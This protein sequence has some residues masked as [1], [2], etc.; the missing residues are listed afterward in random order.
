MEEASGVPKK[1]GRATMS[2]FLYKSIQEFEL[3]VGYK[4]NDTF[5]D[6]W[7]MGRMQW[8]ERD[9]VQAKAEPST[10]G[11]RVVNKEE[12]KRQRLLRRIERRD[13]KI[14]GMEDRI[15][16]LERA[17]VGRT[18][19][20]ENL[21]RNIGREVQNALCNVRMIPVNGLPR[22]D[23]IVDVRIFSPE[24]LKKEKGGGNDE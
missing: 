8:S 24:T 12:A 20:L 19:D 9:S 5:K 11:F 14:K 6:G 23:R 22:M 13:K 10:P 3:A 17:L 18:L 2:D 1:H 16:M 4:V 21:S 7:R 15:R